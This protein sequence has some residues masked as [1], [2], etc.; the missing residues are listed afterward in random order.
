MRYLRERVVRALAADIHRS[1]LADWEDSGRFPR[2]VKLGPGK[3]GVVGW[4]D[5]EIAEWLELG[6][7]EW[8]ARNKD[9]G[10]DAA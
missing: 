4:R 5:T 7:D 3:H 10:N 9:D 6:P 1:T 2:R 8:A